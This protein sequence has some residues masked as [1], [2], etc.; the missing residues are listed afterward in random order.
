MFLIDIFER[1]TVDKTE[2]LDKHHIVINSSDPHQAVTELPEPDAQA[3]QHSQRLLDNI[4]AECEKVGGAITF[5]RYMELA[6][7][8]PNFGYYAAGLNKFGEAGDFI[9]APEISPFFHTVWLAS[10]L[11]FYLPWIILL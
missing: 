3:Q 4:K 8:E 6:L 2:L 5:R 11:K 7:Y 1:R 10:V 9:T